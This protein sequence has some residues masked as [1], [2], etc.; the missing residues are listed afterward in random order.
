MWT[1]FRLVGGEVTGSRHH[2]PFG[3][4]GPGVSMQVGSTQLTSSTWWEFVGLV[5][6]CVRLFVI[7]WAVGCQTPLSMEFSRQEYWSG[8]PFPSSGDLPDPEIKPKSLMSPALAGKFFTTEPL[9]KS[10][11]AK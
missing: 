1:L 3:S 2:R 6:R 11:E 5:L 10:P 4:N 9:G 8:L 7:P